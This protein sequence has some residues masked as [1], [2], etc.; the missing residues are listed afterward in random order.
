[1]AH[2]VARIRK[3]PTR[4]AV[5]RRK[6]AAELVAQQ[7]ALP[8]EVVD[9]LRPEVRQARANYLRALRR[10]ARDEDEVVWPGGYD[11][12]SR[13]QIAYIR[14]ALRALGPQDRKQNVYDAFL[15]LIGNIDRDTGEITL[16]RKELAEELGIL[17]RHVSAVMGTLARLHVVRR[18]YESNRVTYFVNANVAWNGDLDLRKVEAAKSSKPSDVDEEPV[19]APAPTLKLMQG[20][21]ADQPHAVAPGEAAA[22]PSAKAPRKRRRASASP[23]GPA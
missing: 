7:Y 19:P 9:Q 17:P 12:F 13:R 20:G 2:N 5:Q 21:L 4:E 11:M 3:L 1:M 8:D 6:L 16:S 10:Q 22:S 15:L 23:V 14:K 18:E